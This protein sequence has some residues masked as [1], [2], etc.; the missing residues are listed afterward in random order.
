MN[1]N[2]EGPALI[3]NTEVIFNKQ[4]EKQQ[5]VNR[6][7]SND[8]SILTEKNE[9]VSVTVEKQL[10]SVSHINEQI[11]SI[12]VRIDDLNDLLCSNNHLLNTEVN[13]KITTLRE[14][15]NTKFGE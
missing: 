5:E 3:S 1:I 10:K 12:L 14:Y 7:I 8:L 6:K 11:E 13:E 4:F 15:I 2:G 9:S